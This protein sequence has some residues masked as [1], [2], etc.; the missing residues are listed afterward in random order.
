MPPTY[1]GAVDCPE[2]ERHSFRFHRVVALGA[3]RGALRR[4]VIRMK[5]F[6]EFPLSFAV[7]GLLAT[8]LA[9][10]LVD[11]RPD[12][13]VPIPKYWL[14]RLMLGTNTS[15]VLAE[16]IGQRHSRPVAMAL[17]SAR[18][19]SKQSLLGVEQRRR[20]IAGSL[21]VARGYDLAGANVLVVDDTMT[22]GATANEAARV[23]RRAGARQVVIG[24][25]A[26]AMPGRVFGERNDFRP[27]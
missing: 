3:Y 19:T 21:R 2:C 1:A 5:R 22:S 6:A 15:E 23:L 10:R 27:A 18:L 9:E 8:R 7:G 16:A 12:V 14:R 17:R 11:D 26:R 4:A 24:V 13:I 20:N 25:V